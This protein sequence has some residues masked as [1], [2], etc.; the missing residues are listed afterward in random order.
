MRLRGKK[1]E[2]RRSRGLWQL[3]T[4][5]A[6][7]SEVVERAIAEGPQRVTRHGKDAVVVVAAAAFDGMSKRL[8][9]PGSLIAFFQQSPLAG[10]DLELARDQN[11]SR[12]IDL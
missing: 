7:F 8:K 11:I 9:Q 10:V 3:Q 2:L 1:R 12:D 5:K 6:R 4:A